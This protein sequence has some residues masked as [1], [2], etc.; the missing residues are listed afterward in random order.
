MFETFE[1]DVFNA[2]VLFIIQGVED[3]DID[4]DWYKSECVISSKSDCYFVK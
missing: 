4:E 2:E 1:D 3:E